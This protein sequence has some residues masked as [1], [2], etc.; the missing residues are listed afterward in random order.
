MSKSVESSVEIP[1]AMPDNVDT[2]L[3]QQQLLQ[4][5]TQNQ[6]DEIDLAELWRV[7]WAGKF[8]IIIISIIFAIASVLFTI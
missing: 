5:N 6:D 3:L 1:K 2:Q 4:Q 8:I 7:V